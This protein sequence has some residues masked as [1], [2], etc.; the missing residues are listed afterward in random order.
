MKGGSGGTDIYFC[1]REGEKWSNPTNLGNVINTFGNEM[2]PFIADNG[3]LYFASDGQP[4]FGGLDIF[5]S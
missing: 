4:G 1:T 5:V 2:F 3:D